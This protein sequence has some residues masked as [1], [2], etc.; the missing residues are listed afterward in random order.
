MHAQAYTLVGQGACRGAGGAQDKV[1]SRSKAGLDKARASAAPLSAHI[2]TPSRKADSC[3]SDGRPHA[4][5]RATLSLQTEAMASALA[6]RP[7]LTPSPSSSASCTARACPARARRPM[8][9]S[10]SRMSATPLA[11]APLA[12]RLSLSWHLLRL[13]GH[14]GQRLR[15]RVGHLDGGRVDADRHLGAFGRGGVLGSHR[16]RADSPPPASKPCARADSPPPAST[17]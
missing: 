9:P 13:I 5:R 3:S 17:P 8:T 16:A 15:D 12:R 7:I 4:R 14:H 10:C 6:T 11:P 2:T 1:N